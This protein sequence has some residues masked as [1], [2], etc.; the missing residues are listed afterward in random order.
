MSIQGVAARQ[1]EWRSINGHVLKRLRPSCSITLRMAPIL[2]EAEM[3]ESMQGSC[4]QISG[5]EC[6]S[7]TDASKGAGEASRR[8]DVSFKRTAISENGSVRFWFR[9]T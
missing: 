1:R 6:F 4:V 3:E 5:Y 8:V 7:L 2:H 9:L